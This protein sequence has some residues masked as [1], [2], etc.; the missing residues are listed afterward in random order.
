MT[1]EFWTLLTRRIIP[2][3]VDNSHGDRKS[4]RAGVEHLFQMTIHRLYMGVALTTD[5]LGWSSKYSRDGGTMNE[6]IL[7][8][9]HAIS[10]IPVLHLS[11][12]VT[13]FAMNCMRKDVDKQINR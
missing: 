10:I 2:V 13:I 5:L 3:S 9:D 11:N 12:F 6:L 7:K 4:P 1:Q 8:Y